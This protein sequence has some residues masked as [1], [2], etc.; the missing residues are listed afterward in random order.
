MTAASPRTGPDDATDGDDVEFGVL[1][2]LQM[3]VGGELVPLGTPKQRAVLAVL[4]VNA[5]RPVDIDTLISAAWDQRPPPGARAT[6]HAYISNLRRLMR[7]AGIDRALLASAPPGYRLTVAPDQ[8]DLGRFRTKKDAGVHAA[9]AAQFEQASRLMSDALAQWRGPFLED[10]RDFQFVETLATAFDEEKVVA[11]TAH[12]EAQI[13]CGRPDAVIMELQTLIDEHAYR[14]PLWAQLITAYYLAG[15]QS[16]ALDAYL[17]LKTRLA[18]DLGIDPG[19]KLRE[20]YEQ[21]L[22]QE[23][24]DVRRAAQAHAEDTLVSSVAVEGNATPTRRPV[25]AAL[26]AADGQRYALTVG[27]ATRIGRS[28]DND[29]VLSDVKVSRHHAVIT[30]NGTALTITDL[31][32]VNGVRVDGKRIDPSAELRDGDR[33][34]IGDQE[35]TLETK[36]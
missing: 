29:I 5:N 22:R 33:L 16:D 17:R 15:R 21:V 2:P 19:P 14:E 20:L 1:G 25:A 6:L 34:R 4:V 35:F 13:A 7:G 26:R 9:A 11:H 28:S 24:V 31:G 12:V 8:S 27:T 30:D 32:S 3:S 10:L 18:E 36:R 23:E